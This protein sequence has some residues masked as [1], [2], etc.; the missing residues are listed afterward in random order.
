MKSSVDQDSSS[1][2]VKT[3]AQ[4]SLTVDMP[5]SYG[6]LPI[7]EEEITSINVRFLYS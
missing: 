6:R 4:K 3:D 2:T 7:S 5:A 1:K